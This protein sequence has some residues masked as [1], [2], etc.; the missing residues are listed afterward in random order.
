MAVEDRHPCVREILCTLSQAVLGALDG[1]ITSGIGFLTAQQAAITAQ[2][3]ALDVAALPV[4]FVFNEATKLI[5]E[6]RSYANLVPLNLLGAC[7]DLGDLAT[8]LNDTLDLGLAEAETIKNDIVSLLSFKEELN[9]LNQEITDTLAYYED[10][11]DIIA[12][13]AVGVV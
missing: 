13:C 8:S 11:K 4:Q 6:V 2:L 12:T 7:A 5:E 1:I 3:L 9:L 10:I